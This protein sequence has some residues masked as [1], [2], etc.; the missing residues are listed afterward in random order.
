M[1]SPLSWSRI[2]HSH[3]SCQN[4]THILFNANQ[5][6]FHHVRYSS[7]EIMLMRFICVHNSQQPRFKKPR[8]RQVILAS[9]WSTQPAC[10]WSRPEMRQRV[11]ET[12]SSTRWLQLTAKPT[13]T[14]SLPDVHS[15]S[16]YTVRIIEGKG[17]SAAY[18]ECSI[19]NSGP[20]KCF[21]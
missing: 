17:A 6:I 8:S 20:G 11:P 18:L 10:G 9:D 2:G 14:T 3:C 21:F 7:D 12:L 16:A 5:F 15:E 13:G 19:S 4:H 1:Y